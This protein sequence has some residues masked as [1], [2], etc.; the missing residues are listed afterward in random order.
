MGWVAGSGS[1][2]CAI[3]LPTR[4]GPPS[5]PKISKDTRQTLIS[6][7]QRKSR[8]SSVLSQE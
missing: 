6:L 2:P 8:M 1:W 3:L 7:L 4:F 5:G